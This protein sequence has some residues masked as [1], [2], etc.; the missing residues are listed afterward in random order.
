MDNLATSETAID[1][2][3]LLISLR[4]ATSSSCIT[5]LFLVSLLSLI[6]YLNVMA[7]EVCEM[8]GRLLVGAACSWNLILSHCF[9]T[10]LWE[11]KIIDLLCFYFAFDQSGLLPF[12]LHTSPDFPG[13]YYIICRFH[14]RKMILISTNQFKIVFELT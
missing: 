3:C 6:N 7:I 14:H 11:E 8:G 13:F 2:S 5:H 12:L 9:S 1:S 10:F 4:W